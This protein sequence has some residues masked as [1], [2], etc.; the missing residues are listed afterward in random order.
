MKPKFDFGPTVRY[1]LPISTA[2]IRPECKIREINANLNQTDN[3]YSRLLQERFSLEQEYQDLEK[4]I[5][6]LNREIYKQRSQIHE[7]TRAVSRKEADEAFCERFRETMEYVDIEEFRARSEIM[8]RGTSE[9]DD[10]KQ[11]KEELERTISYNSV[12][13]LAIDVA[14]EWK[15][16]VREREKLEALKAETQ[17]IQQKII[18]HIDSDLHQLLDEQRQFITELEEDLRLRIEENANLKSEVKIV[19][20]ENSA[21]NQEIHDLETTM[22][23]VQKTLAEKESEY[24]ALI[25]EQ[26]KER[27]EIENLTRKLQKNEKTRSLGL[28]SQRRLFVGIFK[29]CIHE[30]RIRSIFQ[31]F[32]PIES[33]KI[34]TVKEKPV[35]FFANV[36]FFDP[37]DAEAAVLSMNHKTV[38]NQ[39]INVRWA[40][41][42]P[43]ELDTADIVMAKQEYEKNK[44]THARIRSAVD[45]RPAINRRLQRSK[46]R[47]EESSASFTEAFLSEEIV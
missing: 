47:K 13:R 5:S 34:I 7:L 43:E 17:Q 22:N 44:E 27:E 16:V 29:Q 33:V 14:N 37:Y 26:E 8:S 12:K 36:Q 45:L 25:A 11:S 10:V 32:G 30:S 28:C 19:T 35:K 6:K 1:V 2:M 46:E 15:C 40:S 4:E 39:K 24:T 20:G 21:R 18:T 41:Q 31:K 3:V 42:Q 9:L 38:F 23:K